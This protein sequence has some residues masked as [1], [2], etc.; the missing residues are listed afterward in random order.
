MSRCRPGSSAVSSTRSAARLP[1]SRGG[2]AGA[3]AQCSS[4]SAGRSSAV[5][6]RMRLRALP[7]VEDRVVDLRRRVA[8]LQLPRDVV[9]R[10]AAASRDDLAHD[11][12]L[13]A[14]LELRDG[15]AIL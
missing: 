10:P 11:V 1:G 7:D 4:R 3:D 6:R 5:R 12:V 15:A 8:L 2:P 9:L 13:L 14:L